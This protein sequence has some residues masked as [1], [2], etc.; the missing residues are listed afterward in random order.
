MELKSSEFAD[1]VGVSQRQINNYRKDGMPSVQKGSYHYYNFEAIQ[2]L[3]DNGIKQINRVDDS[4]DVEF[5]PARERKDLADAKNKEFDLDVKQGKY[6]LKDEVKSY[7]VNLGVQIREIL[8]SIPDRFI[9]RLE[10]DEEVKHY[11]RVELKEE[12]YQTLIKLRDLGKG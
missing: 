12:I 5:L 9:P 10:L 6:L 2:W 3:Y 1:L 4:D 11:L 7:S 8:S